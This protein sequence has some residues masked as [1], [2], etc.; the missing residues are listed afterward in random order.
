MKKRIHKISICQRT[1]KF[2]KHLYPH[3]KLYIWQ[4]FLMFILSE[5]LD[6]QWKD[7]FVISAFNQVY[8]KEH[9]EAGLIVHTD[10]GAQFT[11]G[12]F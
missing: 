1:S 11:G 10:Q 7:Q 3:K 9:P 5:L 12:N 4:Y 2:F 6:G 8:G